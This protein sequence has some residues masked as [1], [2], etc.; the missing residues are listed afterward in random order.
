MRMK[1]PQ[2][3]KRL[4]LVIVT[5]VLLGGCAQPPSRRLEE[6]RNIV[7]H[8]YASGAAEFAPGEYQLSSSAL[9]AAEQQMKDRD[10]RQA[11]RTLE[12]AQ[13]YSAEALSLTI[14]IKRQLAEEQALITKQKRLEQLKLEQ[15]K[16]HELEEQQRLARELKLKQ[17]QEAERRKELL[18]KK[19][20][21][22]A[23]I[24][25]PVKEDAPAPVAAQLVFEIQVQA[26]ESLA[27]ISARPEVYDDSDLWPLIYKANRDQIKDPREIFV[28]Q[29][30]VIPRDKSN[31]E[32]DAAR[33]EAQALNLF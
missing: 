1:T 23:K 19:Q 10:Y 25:V 2:M 17:E 20:E 13:R 9:Q 14:E 5:L 29:N 8:A 7:A 12:L 24:S 3:Y 27:D 22:Q 33:Q 11:Q 28:G 15:Q 21:R 18:K 26:G 32:I 16:K 4:L 31:A 6:V 30:L